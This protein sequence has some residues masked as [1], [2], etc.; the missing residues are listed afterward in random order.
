M[1]ST[2]WAIVSILLL[3]GG[4]LFG[5]FKTKTEGFGRFTTSVLVL[6]LALTFSALLLANGNLDSQ[7]FTNV[8]LGVVGFASG[9]VVGNNK[10]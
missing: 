8:V 7:A 1:N 10:Q 2:N 4:A 6:F 3:G 5:F 9:L